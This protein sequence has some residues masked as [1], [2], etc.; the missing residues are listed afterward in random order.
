MNEENNYIHTLGNNYVKLQQLTSDWEKEIKR[1]LSFLG[2]TGLGNSF[3]SSLKQ[4]QKDNGL[5]ISGIIFP[6]DKTNRKL[7]QLAANPNNFRPTL[8]ELPDTSDL[9][10]HE[11]LEKMFNG[12]LP[13]IKTDPQTG[14][15]SAYYLH[16][17]GDNSIPS[18]FP[19]RPQVPLSSK[20][21]RPKDYFQLP[22][23]CHNP[24]HELRMHS[25]RLNRGNSF[26]S[27]FMPDHTG[28]SLV[29]T[30]DDNR[31][32]INM[33]DLEKTDDGKIIFSHT[34]TPAQDYSTRNGIVTWSTK[35]PDEQAEYFD[36]V[37]K[38]LDRKNASH[39]TVANDEEATRIYNLMGFENELINAAPD[40]WKPKY[41][42][43]V[44]N[45]NTSTQ[46]KKDNHLSKIK[47]DIEDIVGNGGVG[48]GWKGFRN[49]NDH[50]KIVD[51][52]RYALL[53]TNPNIDFSKI[54]NI[55]WQDIN[56]PQGEI[57]SFS[58]DK[59]NY[60]VYKAPNGYNVVVQY[61]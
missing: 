29:S 1:N 58:D 56:Q 48:E 59:R 49:I 51:A 20:P 38:Y 45:C 10:L 17:D 35:I 46:W 44:D 55:H 8:D 4:F 3:T 22:E 27:A 37:Q 19:N 9:S 2:Y 60:I 7:D 13:I 11:E 31:K 47:E 5:D 6:K 30:C 14:F 34:Y 18:P 12:S 25:R 57:M 39:K 26:S 50:Y 41:R 24:K 53:A 61:R 21:Q 36:S 40:K 54:A 23:D 28:Y 32:F 33:Q 43:L 16:E 42:P 52:A 15:R